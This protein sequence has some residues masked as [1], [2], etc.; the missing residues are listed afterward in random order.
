[1]AAEFLILGPL[2]IRQDGRSLALG[3][4]RRREL[5]AALLL[6]AGELVS[7]DALIQALWGEEAAPRL[8]RVL[9]RGSLRLLRARRP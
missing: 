4:K 7:A 8:T 2:E 3:G 1:V 9:L 6:C 5:I